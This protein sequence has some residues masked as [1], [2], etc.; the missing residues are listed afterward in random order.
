MGT[1]RE[2]QLEQLHKQMQGRKYKSEDAKFT[3]ANYANYLSFNVLQL[4]SIANIVACILDFGLS[5]FAIVG[6]VVIAIGI[7]GSAYIFFRN[8]E[9]RKLFYF[10]AAEFIPLYII[11]IFTNG[12]DC[13]NCAPVIFLV[14]AMLYSNKKV[15]TVLCV[16][17][18][19]IVVVR[20]AALLGGLIT[21]ANTMNEELAV[22]LLVVVALIV[23]QQSTRILWQFNQDSLGA[24]QDEDEIQKL[25]MEEILEIAGEV[26]SQTKDAS[27]ILENL[28]DSALHIDGVVEEITQG[29][30]STAE[31]IQSQTE[32]TQSI[33]DS[34]NQTAETV[35]IAV[36]KALNSMESV[37]ANLALMTEL[38][39]HSHKIE[40]TNAI[41][42]SSM[43]A[44]RE[45]TDDVKDITNMI[46][47]ISSQTNLL[48][49]NASIEAARAGEAGKGFSVVA[50]QIRQLAEQTREATENIT[51]IVTQLNELSEEASD[52]VKDSLNATEMQN[53]LIGQALEEFRVINANMQ[54][55]TD[56][57]RAIDSMVASLKESNN[58][59]VGSISQLSAVSQEITANSSHASGI[60]MENSKSSEQAK[61]KLQSVIDC[62]RRLDK[63]TGMM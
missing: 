24:I 15:E 46:L 19:L 17:F 60:T 52:A 32:M 33:Q 43:G 28:Y 47:N 36:E 4:A 13:M 49:L 44:L 35:K 55:M 45:K 39:E 9:S 8:K 58:V 25:M 7:C 38:G 3:L 31:S 12:N 26:Q 56:E 61:N 63:Y 50:D 57:M 37:N 11:V 16:V 27:H 18:G 51:E 1:N 54:T 48:A 20:Y 2:E 23:I 29:T 22:M 14:V 34:I 41:V 53:Q 6:L 21:T 62:A 40:D 5:I 59:I 42:V 30:Q 10:C